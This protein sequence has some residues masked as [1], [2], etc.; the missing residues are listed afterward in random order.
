MKDDVQ[1][2][3]TESSGL[4]GIA[5]ELEVNTKPDAETASEYVKMISSTLKEIEKKRKEFTQPINE[6]LRR[7]NASFKEISDPLERA[8]RQLSGKIVAWQTEQQ[9]AAEKARRE[10]EEKER[11]INDKLKAQGVQEKVTLPIPKE[12]ENKLGEA[13]FREMWTFEI[14]DESLI[15]RD[16]LTVDFKK[17]NAAIREGVREIAGVKVYKKKTLVA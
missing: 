5:E 7:M 14:E 4:I 15:P 6:S 17:I 2:L 12:P 13:H 9:A 1:V 8:K 3:K 16:F 11:R 10:A